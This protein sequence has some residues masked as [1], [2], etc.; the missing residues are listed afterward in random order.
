MRLSASRRGMSSTEGVAGNL[1]TGGSIGVASSPGSNGIAA[2]CSLSPST[3][4][5]GSV[6][7]APFKSPSSCSTRSVISRVS[8]SAEYVRCSAYRRFCSFSSYPLAGRFFRLALPLFLEL[9]SS[10]LGFASTTLGFALHLYPNATA[11]HLHDSL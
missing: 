4:N 11:R 3:S 9:V 1:L 7:K 5:D 6:D 10:S 2:G 8:C